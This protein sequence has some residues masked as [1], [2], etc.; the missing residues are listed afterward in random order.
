MLYHLYFCENQIFT[1]LNIINQLKMELPKYNP[2]RK[3]G[4]EGVTIVKN[5]IERK[6][7]WVFRKITLDDD[8]G[9]DGYI[10]ILQEGQ[11]VTGKSIGIQIKT[12]PS[13]FKT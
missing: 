6:L 2:K 13:Y 9:L 4:E 12:G 5:I 3:K 10:D 1:Y 11:Y 7:N 8:F